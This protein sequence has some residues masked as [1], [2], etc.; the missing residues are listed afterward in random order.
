MN[1][2]QKGIATI[3]LH[4]HGFAHFF[5]ILALALIAVVGIGYYAY[6][7]GQIKLT[8]VS[9]SPTQS[10]IKEQIIETSDWKIYTNNETK[11]TIKVPKNFNI[12]D[13]SGGYDWIYISDMEL[14]ENGLP[15]ESEYFI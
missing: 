14:A 9:T 5:L 3:S 11:F 1:K 4:N 2:K 7:N 15:V 6:K 10:P 12:K 13:H 8:Q